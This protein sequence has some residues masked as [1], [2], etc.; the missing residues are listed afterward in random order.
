MTTSDE[1]PIHQDECP[2]CGADL[3]LGRHVVGCELAVEDH[4][5]D[6]DCLTFTISD[7]GEPRGDGEWTCEGCGVVHRAAA[8]ACSCGGRGFHRAGCPE[9]G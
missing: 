7:G 2:K 1:R 3:S 8:D 6:E 5:A 4:T 9:I